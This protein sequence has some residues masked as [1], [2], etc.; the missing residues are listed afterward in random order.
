M[1]SFSISSLPS[2]ISNWMSSICFRYQT[3]YYYMFSGCQIHDSR[4]RLDDNSTTF[5][6]THPTSP[7]PWRRLTHTPSTSTP[8]HLNLEGKVNLS[9]KPN[10][11]P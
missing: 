6:V 3:L 5:N 11:K 1:L 8:F 7:L 2:S 9:S 4:P 10:N